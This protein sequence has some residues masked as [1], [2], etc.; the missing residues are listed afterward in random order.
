MKAGKSQSE[1]GKD[2]GWKSPVVNRH[3]LGNRALDGFAIE[4]YAR[5]YNVSPYEIFVPAD[6][7]VIYTGD[8]PKPEIPSAR[9]AAFEIIARDPSL[10]DA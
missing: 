3:E 10:I 1:V 6:Y 2:L 4:R 9:E 8:Y 5:Y 7:L